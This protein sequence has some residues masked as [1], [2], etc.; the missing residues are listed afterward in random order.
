VAVFGD[1]DVRAFS[2][3]TQTGLYELTSAFASGQP[4][5]AAVGVN[6]GALNESDLRAQAAPDFQAG[7][8]AFTGNPS[9][10]LE[11]WP[12]LVGLLAAALLLEA[13]FAWR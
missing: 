1:G 12:L 9:D 10:G 2:G 5:R 7:R 13:H 11:L 4:W 6:A 8:S 3:T